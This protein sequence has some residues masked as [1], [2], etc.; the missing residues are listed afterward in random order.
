MA[1]PTVM[2]PIESCLGRTCLHWAAD[3]EL[4]RLDRDLVL[5]RLAQVDRDVDALRQRG[6]QPAACAS[7]L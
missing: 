4:S 6:L 5:E 3:G 7:S 2:N 1:D